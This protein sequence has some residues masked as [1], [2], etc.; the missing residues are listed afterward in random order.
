MYISV[1]IGIL[2]PFFGTV[3]GSGCVYLLK[4]EINTKVKKFL[5]GFASGVMISA[6][7]WSLLIP[8]MDIASKEGETPWLPASIGFLLGGRLFTITRYSNSTFTC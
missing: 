2:I 1:L 5:L 7:V 8:S 6:S 4:D 3:L